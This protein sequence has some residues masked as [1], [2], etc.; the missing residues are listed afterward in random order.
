MRFVRRRSNNLVFQSS[1]GRSE[2]AVGLRRRA[3]CGTSF[4]AL[5]P[6]RAAIGKASPSDLAGWSASARSAAGN[7]LAKRQSSRMDVDPLSVLDGRSRPVDR[8]ESSLRN[9][10]VRSES[11]RHFQGL[12]PRTD[13]TVL[14]ALLWKDLRVNRLPLLIAAAMLI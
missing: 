9:R 7:D 1:A 11:G 8:C 4:G 2:S 5:F 13:A 3:L 6:G 14:R 12:Y 10:S